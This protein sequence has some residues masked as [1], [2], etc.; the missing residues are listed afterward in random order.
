M[1]APETI[2]RV[3]KVTKSFGPRRALH[4]VSL[5]VQSGEKMVITGPSGAGK[6]TLLRS[7]NGLEAIDSGRIVVNGWDVT[8]RH[9]DMNRIRME[10][11]MV[12]GSPNLFPHKKVLENLTLAPEKLRGTP[13]KEAEGEGLRLLAKVGLANKALFYPAQLSGGE[14][15]RV[16]IAR[17]LAM[18]PK[19]MLFDDPTSA[20]HPAMSAEV[21]EV[22]ANLAREGMA[23][24]VVS[25][26]MGFALEVADRLVVMDRGEVLEMG[27]PAGLIGN[28]G[29]PRTRKFLAQIL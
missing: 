15:Q 12:F 23:M 28:P 13:Q 17:A 8:D 9:N 11:G 4:E 29:C 27:H 14:Q 5:A 22:M 10:M 7:I 18:H 6:S 25:H 16:A 2:I 3:E 21:L 19:V 24:V 26:E 1:Y 20:L